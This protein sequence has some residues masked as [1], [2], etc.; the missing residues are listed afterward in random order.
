MSR[1]RRT[2]VRHPLP[3]FSQSSTGCAP[4]RCRISLASDGGLADKPLLL[5]WVPQFITTKPLS[6]LRDGKCGI[7]T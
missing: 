5:S 7:C 4:N 1:R 6:M 3:Y 2:R